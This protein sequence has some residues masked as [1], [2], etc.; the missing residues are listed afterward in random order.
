[1]TKEKEKIVL[2][3]DGIIKRIPHRPP[4]LFVDKIIELN[5]NKNAIGI[6]NVTA[7]E[8]FFA[9]HFPKKPVMPG[10]LI[11]EALAQTAGVLVCDS[12]QD[13][14]ESQG[15]LFSHIDFVKFRKVVVPGDQLILEVAILKNRLGFWKCSGVAKV[16][17]VVAVETE[18]TAKIV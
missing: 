18:F 17:G 9:G 14:K 15:V 13:T 11:V 5:R 4:F 12:L 1:M 10:V 6:K 2:D 16:D 3:Y 8:Q 7:N